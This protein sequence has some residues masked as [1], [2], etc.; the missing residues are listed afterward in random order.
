MKNTQRKAQ[1]INAKTHYL[2][3]FFA[4]KITDTSDCENVSIPAGQRSDPGPT[5]Y[6]QKFLIEILANDI[7][8]STQQ[9]IH[10]NI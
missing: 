4:Q 8:K 1:G 2:L 6:H 7:K 3:L 10:H 5:K 9:T